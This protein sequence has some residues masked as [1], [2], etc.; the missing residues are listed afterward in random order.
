MPKTEAQTM[1]VRLPVEIARDLMKLRNEK[2][3]STVG[4]ALKYWIEQQSN[5]RIESK[6]NELEAAI[7]ESNQVKQLDQANIILNSSMISMI[8]KA[9]GPEKITD[10]KQAQ[11]KIKD[12]IKYLEDNQAAINSFLQAGLDQGKKLQK[13]YPVNS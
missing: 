10:N 9:I 8:L 4:S 7:R 3:L 13:K 11:K 1:V 5:E 12:G 6:L 2:N